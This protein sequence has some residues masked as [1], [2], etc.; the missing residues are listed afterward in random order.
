MFRVKMNKY[1]AQFAEVLILRSTGSC[2][3]FGLESK[4]RKQIRGNGV[5]VLTTQELCFQMYLPTREWRIPLSSITSIETPKSHLGKT[6]FRP[7]LMVKFINNE[8]LPDSIAWWI[9]ELDKWVKDIQ[10]AREKAKSSF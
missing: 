3:F 1:L 4:G 10:Q 8:G 9:L 5:L 2:N 7:L 6:K